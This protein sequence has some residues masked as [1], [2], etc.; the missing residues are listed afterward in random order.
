MPTTNGKVYLGSVLIA[1]GSTQGGNTQSNYELR[2]S[3]NAALVEIPLPAIT[4][5]IVS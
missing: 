5:T 1:S 4:L 2:Y 3:S